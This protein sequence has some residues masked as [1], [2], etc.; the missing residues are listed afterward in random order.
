MV[1]VIATWL[2]S[3]DAGDGEVQSGFVSGRWKNKLE[4][5]KALGVKVLSVYGLILGH[6]LWKHLPQL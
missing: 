2:Y 4:V 5:K 3:E 6:L 1:V